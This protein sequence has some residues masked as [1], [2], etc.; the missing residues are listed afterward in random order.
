MALL[1]TFPGQLAMTSRMPSIYTNRGVKLQKKTP[2]EKRVRII[3]IFLIH[4]LARMLTF[5]TCVFSS[6]YAHFNLTSN[7]DVLLL[8][9]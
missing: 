5:F 8:Q 2:S 9:S 1:L 6:H 4:V 3:R 7:L